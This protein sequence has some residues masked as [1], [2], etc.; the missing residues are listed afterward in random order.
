MPSF[1]NMETYA[2]APTRLAVSQSADRFTTSAC[3]WVFVRQGSPYLFELADE[4]SFSN[5]A[6][7]ITSVRSSVFCRHL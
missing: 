4:L 5:D 1:S 3:R 7:N 6:V 2:D